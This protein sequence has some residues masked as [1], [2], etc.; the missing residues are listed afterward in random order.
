VLHNHVSDD[1]LANIESM[2]SND[3]Y[4]II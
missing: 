1:F 4:A 2:M 3:W